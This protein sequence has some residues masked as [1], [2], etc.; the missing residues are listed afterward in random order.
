MR[1]LSLTI[2]VAG[3]GLVASETLWPGVGY[4]LWLGVALVIA[5]LIARDS[6]VFTTT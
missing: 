2:L 1:I 3:S 4:R 5:W 6:H